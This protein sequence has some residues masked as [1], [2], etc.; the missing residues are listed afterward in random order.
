[1]RSCGFSRHV[2]KQTALTRRP[3]S[4][5]GY[6]SKWTVY[7][8]WCTSEGHSIF[9]P[10]LSKIAD[11]LFWLRR[12]KKLSVSAVM[13][14]RSVLSAVFRSML[15]EISTSAVFYDL[16]RS[17]RVE[18]PVRSVTPPSWDLL[19]VLEFL[20][21]LVFEPLHQSSLRDLQRKTLF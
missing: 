7:R 15:P 17:F 4:R 3:S 10:S 9:R 5:A 13:G 6:Q 20:K 19:K 12:S 18:A 16:L 2:A 1:M 21:S 14:Y 11:F 8:K